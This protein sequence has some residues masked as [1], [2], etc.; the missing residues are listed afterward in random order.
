MLPIQKCM[1]IKVIL[2]R[3]FSEV[4]LWDSDPILICCNVKNKEEHPL[5]VNFEISVLEF[6]SKT[7][8]E[9]VTLVF[10]KIEVMLCQTNQSN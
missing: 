5:F 1:E 10:D 6:H 4:H 3:Y 8:H 9:I 2:K 7:P